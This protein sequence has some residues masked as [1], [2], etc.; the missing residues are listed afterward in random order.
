M[1]RSEDSAVRDI[2]SVVGTPARLLRATGLVA[3]LFLAGT[4]SC[5]VVE[6]ATVWDSFYMTVITITTV[7]FAEQFPLSPASSA[8]VCSRCAVRARE[9]GGTAILQTPWHRAP[10]FMPRTSNPGHGSLY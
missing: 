1:A 4:V 5:R 3:G 2:P 9:V 8:S 6:G 7:G 10:G